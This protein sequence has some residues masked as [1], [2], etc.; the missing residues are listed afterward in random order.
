MFSVNITSTNIPRKSWGE[1]YKITFKESDGSIQYAMLQPPTLPC[2]SP[3]LPDS[4]CPV[5]IALHG[6]GV[7]ASALSWTSA[8]T[9]RPDAWII[10]PT[11]RTPWGFDW[12]GASF[13]NVELALSALETLPGVPE[14]KRND[15]AVDISKLIYS[16][17]SNGGAGAWWFISHFPDRAVAA[18]AVAGYIKMQFYVSYSMR[19]SDAFSDPALRAGCVFSFHY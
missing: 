10:F 5:V 13:N 14:D 17:H 16:G 4:N 1:T 18:V 8:F 3:E 15:T 7:E 12:H 19:V 9:P 11:G 2:A 6:A